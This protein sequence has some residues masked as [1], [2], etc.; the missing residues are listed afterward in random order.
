MTRT[1]IALLVLLTVHAVSA[2]GSTKKPVRRVPAPAPLVLPPAPGEQLA[3]AAMI[4]IGEYNCELNQRLQVS[5]NPSVDGYVDVKFGQHL[6]TMKPVLS[7]TGALRLEDVRGRMLLLQIPVKS[8]LLDVKA[9]HRLVDECVH[10]QQ[11]EN[12]RAL[13]AA[14]PQPGLGIEPGREIDATAESAGAVAAAEAPAS[15]AS[16]AEPGLAPA[17]VL[18]ASA[19]AG[20]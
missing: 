13:A 6:L 17:P 15:A 10:E 2:Q 12:R 1:L 5:L 4:Y 19:A 3:A 8:M 18:P 11:A 9:G 7:R 20:S 16:A 14:P